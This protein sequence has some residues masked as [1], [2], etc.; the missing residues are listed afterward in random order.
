MSEPPADCGR[1]PRLVALRERVRRAHPYYHAAPVAAFG[2][3]DA[4]LLGVGLAPGMH[5]ASASGRPFTG[6]AAGVLLYRTPGL[7]AAQSASS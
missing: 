7:P 3:R 6:D 2:L 5:G 4:A 1:C